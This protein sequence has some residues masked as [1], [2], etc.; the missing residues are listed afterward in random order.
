MGGLIGKPADTMPI[1]TLQPLL[2]RRSLPTPEGEWPAAMAASAPNSSDQLALF[3]LRQLP[4]AAWTTARGSWLLQRRQRHQPAGTSMW[5]LFIEGGALTLGGGAETRARD[6]PNAACLLRF[7]D[8]G[9]AQRACH[10]ARTWCDGVTADNGV[11]CPRHDVESSL[12]SRLAG[13]R[14][15]ARSATLGRRQREDEPRPASAPSTAG[16]LSPP[17]GGAAARGN[18]IGNETLVVLLG[19]LRGGEPTWESMYRHLLDPLS[20]DLALAIG[21][22]GPSSAAHLAAA[23]LARRA[24]H[25]WV[26]AEPEEWGGPLDRIAHAVGADPAGWRR[27]AAHAR[28]RDS[29]LYG[30]VRVG[31]T[32]LAGSGAIIFVLRWWVLTEH[33][34]TLARYGRIILSRADHYY[35]CDH[36]DV[37]P[38]AVLLRAGRQAGGTAEAAAGAAR[39]GVAAWRYG[40]APVDAARSDPPL[41]LVT[42]GRKT[43]FFGGMT[44]RHHVFAPRDADAILSVAAWMVRNPMRTVG[45]TPEA[46]IE[47]AWADAGVWSASFARTMFTVAAIGDSTR[48]QRART[49]ACDLPSMLRLKYVG[50]Y[51]LAQA[52]CESPTL[53]MMYQPVTPRLCQQ[54][55]SVC[56]PAR[57]PDKLSKTGGREV[58]GARMRG[59]IRNR[60]TSAARFA[61]RIPSVPVFGGIG[62]NSDHQEKPTLLCANRH[63][64]QPFGSGVQTP[65]RQ[66]A[67]LCY[68]RP[69]T[70]ERR[71]RRRAGPTATAK[72]T[73]APAVHTCLSGDMSSILFASTAAEGA[74]SA[75]ADGENCTG[76]SG[77]NGLAFA[78]I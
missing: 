4:F 26:Y 16:A 24:K 57:D 45:A 70:P 11:V 15:A 71:Q 23:S 7:H 13:R 3:T 42:E 18:A 51:M 38:A 62:P 32:T 14:A 75:G 48:W 39:A 76:S 69:A 54:I 8:L 66:D 34:A 63:P 2:P 52:R 41:A 28:S 60:T 73:A 17:S 33:R 47:Y 74:T 59:G 72:H 10:R 50:E 31:G 19:S 20:A 61:M 67:V 1:I 40:A 56:V 25:V 44:D 9:A 35:R 53:P 36:P 64:V 55:C 46:V 27:A 30:G 5:W 12:H 37:W 43:W 6:D 22:S 21:S 65:R 49:R 68:P 78:M 77:A 29:G 58:A